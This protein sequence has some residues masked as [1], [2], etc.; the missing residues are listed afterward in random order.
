MIFFKTILIFFSFGLTFAGSSSIQGALFNPINKLELNGLFYIIGAM[1]Y[2]TM[3]F[4]TIKLT[5]S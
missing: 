1:V 3:L 5:Y 4:I 2:I